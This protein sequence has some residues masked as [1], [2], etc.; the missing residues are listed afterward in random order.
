[1][2][3]SVKNCKIT[4]GVSILNH[5]PKSEQYHTKMAFTEKENLSHLEKTLP[6]PEK[7]YK[8]QMWSLQKS[9]SCAM[10]FKHQLS[11][12]VFPEKEYKLRK[13]EKKKGTWIIL[14]ELRT[15]TL[16][17]NKMVLSFSSKEPENLTYIPNKYLMFSKRIE[18]GTKK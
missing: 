2:P 13:K 7:G 9:T 14:V 5:E 18:E 8:F 15:L 6:P 11:Y 4:Q 1:M 16:V 3:K 10:P 12:R 17:C